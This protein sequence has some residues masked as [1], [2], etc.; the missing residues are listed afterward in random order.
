LMASHSEE[1]D[2]KGLGWLDAVT[3]RLSHSDTGR[4]K[5]PHMGWNQVSAKKNS[6]IMTSV[7]QQSVFYFAH[8]YY[9][10]LDDSSTDNL[11]MC[12]ETEYETRFPSVIERENLI[13]VQFQPEKSHDAGRQ[14]LANFV[15]M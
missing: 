14:V 7:A 13:G 8:S 3:V 6:R 4:Y 10:K 9:L 11:A 1:G 5:V 15:R 2:A 12:G